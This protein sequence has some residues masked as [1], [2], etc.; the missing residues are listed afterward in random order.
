MCLCRRMSSSLQNH[1]QVGNRAEGE[2]LS[3]IV[4]RGTLKLAAALLLLAP[5]T[6]LLF[7]GEEYHEKAPFQFFADF[8]DAELRKAVSQGRRS[9]FKD[10]DF[11]QVPDPED[12]ETF[13][14]SKLTWATAP[15]NREMLDWYRR[16]LQLRKQHVTNGEKTADAQY[17]GGVLTLQVPATDPKIMV[18][19]ALERGRPLPEVENGWREALA[20]EEDGYAVRVWVRVR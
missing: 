14:R 15:E 16:L 9:E 7:M 12:P 20:S 17:D 1:D 4:P 11:S 6:P 10:F 5:H 13:R 3:A 18:Q 19:A 8:E 2:R